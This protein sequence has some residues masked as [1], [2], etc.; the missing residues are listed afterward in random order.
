MLAFEQYP[1]ARIV[2]TN[3]AVAGS[4]TCPD[5]LGAWSAGP[6]KCSVPRHLAEFV[7]CH[8]PT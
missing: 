4:E 5:Y 2:W 1:A 6:T 7:N 3:F 8:L